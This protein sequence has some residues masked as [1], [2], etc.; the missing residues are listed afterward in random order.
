MSSRKLNVIAPVASWAWAMTATK[1]VPS[2]INVMWLKHSPGPGRSSVRHG[3]TP[4]HPGQLRRDPPT[5][6]TPSKE[7]RG[8]AALSAQSRHSEDG[9]TVPP[10]R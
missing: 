4:R 8:A 5:P 3:Q 7:G 9:L 1:Q 6:T 10:F 2:S